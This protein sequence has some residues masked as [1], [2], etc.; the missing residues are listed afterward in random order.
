MAFTEIE[1]EAYASLKLS[2]IHAWCNPLIILTS[3]TS[4]LR[5]EQGLREIVWKRTEKFDITRKMHLHTIFSIHAHS[6][7]KYHFEVNYL[8][9]I[10]CWNLA[11]IVGSIYLQ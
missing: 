6:F 3:P 11:V 2:E 9:V 10:S 4:G 7:Y 8:R 5:Q 1:I